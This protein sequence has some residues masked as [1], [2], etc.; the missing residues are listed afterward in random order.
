MLKEEAGSVHKHTHSVLGT[1]HGHG[2]HLQ[3]EREGQFSWA[4]VPKGHL[5]VPL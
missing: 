2:L 5:S 3:G 4:A 1:F